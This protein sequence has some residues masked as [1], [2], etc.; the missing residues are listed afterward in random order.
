M[1]WYFSQATHDTIRDGIFTCTQ[2]LIRGQL[3]LMHGTKNKK[4]RKK[5]KKVRRNNLT[6]I[7]WMQS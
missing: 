6:G 1:D 3:H 2:N 7:P 4:I 5:L